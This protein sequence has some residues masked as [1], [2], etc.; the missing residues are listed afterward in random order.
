M[1]PVLPFDFSTRLPSAFLRLARLTS[2][3]GY[4]VGITCCPGDAVL[5]VKGVIETSGRIVR[6]IAGCIVKVIRAGY[7][8]NLV[9]DGSSYVQIFRRT[10][11]GSLLQQIAPGVIA[12][13]VAPVF[14]QVVYCFLGA[15]GS[16]VL[17]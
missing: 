2:R 14:R 5:L 13:A 17:G 9:G 3:T 16:S 8:M 15:V 10:L 4:G 6:H 1:V 7:G 12:V 11:C